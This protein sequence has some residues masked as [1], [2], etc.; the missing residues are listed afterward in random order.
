MKPTWKRQATATT[1]QEEEGKELEA[2]QLQE[3][4]AAYV[5][6]GMQSRKFSKREA[7]KMQMKASPILLLDTRNTDAEYCVVRGTNGYR[8]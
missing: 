3:N 8:C 5:S 4:V 7:L 6:C 1:F 2:D